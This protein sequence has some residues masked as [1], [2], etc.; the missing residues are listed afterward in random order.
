MKLQT[1]RLE[2]NIARLIVEVELNELDRAKK[3]AAT[4]L[5]TRYKIPGFRKGKVPYNIVVKFIGEGA[6]LE[7]AVEIMADEIYPK[8]LTESGLRPYANGTLDNFTLE[9]QPTYTFTLPLQAEVTLG[10]Y[11]SVRLEYA[12]PEI[13]EDALERT[14]DALRQQEAA[15]TDVEGEIEVGQRI[16]IDLHS[17]F[18]DGEESDESEASD[19]D[20]EHENDD[21]D[22][23]DLDDNVVPSKGDEFIHRHDA[24]VNLNLDND[25]FL[26]GFI[27]QV[28]GKKVG[29]VVEFGL[30]VPTDSTDYANVAGRTVHFEVSIKK[31]QSVVLPELNDAFAQKLTEKEENPLDLEQLRTRV[32]ENLQKE[33]EAEYDSQYSDDVLEK[34]IEI[35]EVTYPELMVDNRVQEMVEEFKSRLKQQ[36]ITFD[37]YKTV[38]GITEEKISDQYRPDAEKFV[39]RSLVLG[40]ILLKEKVTF[41]NSDIDEEVNRMVE[42]YGNSQQMRVFFNTKEQRESIANRV[43]YSKL[44]EQLTAIGK[45]ESVQVLTEGTESVVSAA[46]N[47]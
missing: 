36:K 32:K 44:M 33:A 16:T 18:E 17:H 38:T 7:E 41:A 15:T 46:D 14:M 4:K 20:H 5:S 1:E 27:D 13:N 6:I 31:V 24:A 25:P 29:D 10:D 19:H 43:L 34:I 35:A 2:K 28:V 3:S 30:V 39:V 22:D 47:D 11:G 12:Q 40:E 26:P 8:A 42:Q 9:P 45:G 37:V 23:D 21:S